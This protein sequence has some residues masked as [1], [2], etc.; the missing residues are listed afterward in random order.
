MFGFVGFVYGQRRFVNGKKG[1]GCVTVMS[2]L[3]TLRAYGNNDVKS[4][5]APQERDGEHEA[6]EVAGFEHCAEYGHREDMRTLTC[7]CDT[8]RRRRVVGGFL[9]QPPWR[10]RKRTQT[11]DTLPLDVN[12]D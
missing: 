11:Y 4:L 3:M 7:E 12:N 1:V 8:L 5:N 10:G 9:L 2:Q 6:F